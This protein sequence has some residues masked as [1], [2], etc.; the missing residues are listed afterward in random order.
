VELELTQ[1]LLDIGVRLSS[2]NGVLEEG[3]KTGSAVLESR[4]EGS[5]SLCGV[6]E[7]DALRLR[8]RLARHKVVK[9][10]SVLELGEPAL[11]LGGSLGG[12]GGRCQRA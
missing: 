11:G 10:Q 9:G 3:R 12:I 4:R 2:R 6:A 1:V 7:N 5:G 8:Q